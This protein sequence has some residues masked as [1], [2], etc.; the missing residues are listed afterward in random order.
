MA[1]I[2]AKMAPT[3]LRHSVLPRNLPPNTSG[4]GGCPRSARD[5]HPAA[6]PPH[7]SKAAAHPAPEPHGEEPFTNRSSESMVSMSRIASAR[8]WQ[9]FA[10]FEVLLLRGAALANRLC[11]LV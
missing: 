9:H 10:F 4:H 1:E 5:V 6:H 7:L 11:G 2:D 3:T 8:R